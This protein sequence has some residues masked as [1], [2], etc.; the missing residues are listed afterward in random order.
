MNYT[1]H[2]YS[3]NGAYFLS[4]HALPA[5]VYNSLVKAFCPFEIPYQLHLSKMIVNCRPG[6]T[7]ILRYFQR[8]FAVTIHLR[9]IRFVIL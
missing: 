1:F 4:A 2:W 5:M 7:D 6:A 8:A 9:Y 3:E